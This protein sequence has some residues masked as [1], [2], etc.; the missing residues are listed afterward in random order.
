MFH[1]GP[2][3]RIEIGGGDPLCLPVG[4]PVRDLPGSDRAGDG[5]AILAALVNHD[6]VSLSYPL[7]T[8]SRVEFLTIRHRQGW[9]IYRNTAA[10]LLAKVVHELYPGAAFAVEHSLGNGYYCSFS[11]PG[12]APD[13]EALR[14]IEAG[15][16]DLVQRDAPIVRRKIAYSQALATFSAEGQQDKA[17]L[18]RYRNPPYVVLMECEGFSDLSHGVLAGRAGAISRFRILPYPPGFVLQFPDREQPSELASFDPQPHLFQIFRE[19]KEWG[20]ILG[21]RTVGDLN[22][23]ISGREFQEI[24]RMA[25]AFHEKKIAQIADRIAERRGAVRWL[26]IAGPSSSG[27]TTFSKRLSIQLR[28]NGLRPVILSVDDYFVDRE[29]TPR[30][31]RG[32]PDFEHIETVDLSLFNE[33]L[34]ALDRGEEVSLPSFRFDTGTRE[35]RGARLRLEPDH[36]VILEGIHCLNPRLTEAVP[37]DHKFRIYISAL[38]QLNLDE[39]NRVA[40]TDNRLLRRMVRDHMFRGNRAADT[41][42]MWP[43]VRRGEKTWIFPYQKEADLAFNSALDYE[44]AVLKPL[45]EPLLR[46]IKPDQPEY[47]DARRLLAFLDYFRAVPFSPVPPTSLLREFIGRSGFRY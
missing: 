46:E 30:D 9:R 23:A 24:V 26:L 27:K 37:S 3:V 42:R 13:G 10:F 7:E 22:R 32:E 43:S 8:D 5:L 39:H 15:M 11:P 44:L 47:A 25:E 28:V 36:L 17:D 45:A 6:V 40:T 14:R 2:E 4:S 41:L 16:R 31:E 35:F 38:T 21:L 34:A 20:R 12:G 1:I 33:H 18:L 19:H 29:R